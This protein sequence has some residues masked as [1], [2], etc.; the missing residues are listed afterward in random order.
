MARVRTLGNVIWFLLAGW[1]LF[2]GYAVAGLIAVVLIVTIPFGVASFRLAGYVVWPF[3]RT[4][5]D[6]PSAGVGSAIGNILWLVLI[7]W[8]LALI[9]IVTGVLVALTIIGIPLAVANWKMVPLALWPLGREVVPAEV[10]AMRGSFSV[11]QRYQ[12]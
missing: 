10:A 3:G 8:W 4:V 5:V 7:G 12:P 2:L 11:P 1:E 6:K 9:H